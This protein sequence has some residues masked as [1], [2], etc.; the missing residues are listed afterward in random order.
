[1]IEISTVTN[2]FARAFILMTTL[3]ILSCLPAMAQE[4]EV[5]G[6][7]TEGAAA[8]LPGVSV[9]LKG[10]S[11]GTVTDIDGRYSLSVPANGVLVFSFVGFK[12][13]EI[14][15]SSRSSIDL[16]MELD[17]KALEEIVVVGYGEQ[18]RSDLTGAI[19]TVKSEDIKNLPVNSVADAI[20][21]RVAGVYVT[22]S[23]GE[24][25][26]QPN[27]TI[28][29]PGNLNGVAPLY[30]V[31]GMPFF[32]TGF[33][34]NIQD[35]E[36]IEVIK[37]ASAAAIY[38]TLGSGGVI[39]ITTKKGQ[40][41]RITT[42]A[43]VNYGV[44]RVFNLPELLGRDRYIQ[45]QIANGAPPDQFNG[46]FPD[47]DWFDEL[48]DA[49]IEQNYTAYLSGGGEKST[50]YAS[51]NYQSLEGVRID[52][53]VERYTLRL[54]SEHKVNKRLTVGQTLYGTYTMSNPTQLPNSGPLS[55]RTSPLVPVREPNGEWGRDTFSQRGNAVAE[56]FVNFQEDE[57]YILN[58]SAYVDWEIIDGLHFRTNGGINLENSNSYYFNY[59]FDFGRVERVQE[60]FGR[61]FA[62]RRQLLANYTLMYT[63]NFNDKHDVSAM[64]GYEA[65]KDKFSN[66]QGNAFFPQVPLAQNSD[67]SV[68]DTLNRP[69]F[70]G[71]D[72]YRILSQF[73]RINYSYQGKYLAQF[74]VR[75][76]GVA[77]VFGP[78]NKYGVFP[79]MSLGWKI[80]EEN[81]MA[82]VSQVSNLKLRF[83]LGSLGNFQGID[84]FLF[85]GDFSPGFAVDLGGGKQGSINL[86]NKLPNE[87]IQ[88]ETIRTLNIGVDAGFFENKLT[89]SVDWYDRTTQDMLYQVPL[90]AVAGL[91]EDVQFNIGE[92]KNTGL[93]FALE[94]RSSVGDVSYNI[95]ANGAFNRNELVS[96]SPDVI[97]QQIF[98]GST[99]EAYAFAQASR[100]A[101][102]EPLGQFW[103]FVTDGIYQQDDPDGPSLD[104][105]TPLAG[106]LVYRNI[107]DDDI[108]ND[109][110]K[111][112]IGNPW[113]D[114]NYGITMGAQ[115]K[116]FD[117]QLFFTGVQGVDILNTT[118]SFEHLFFN[119]YHSTEAIYRTSFFDGNG[120]TDLPRSTER[121]WSQISDFNVQDGSFLRLKNL[122]VGYN[123][124]QAWLDKIHASSLRIFFMTDNLF[125]ITSYDGIDPESALS[126]RVTATS[127]TGEVQSRGIDNSTFRYPNSR[128]FSVGVNVE[129]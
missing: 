122:Q 18:K 43:N 91:G 38:G 104:G 60:E 73:G 103:G 82:S 7:V 107:T 55:F 53:L 127:P 15:V 6:R 16:N 75:R 1:M 64:I 113:P 63:K 111:T 90:S 121:N 115:W 37:D 100:S 81:F 88:W 125:T 128:L 32:G 59:A 97:D 19:A 21:G 41:D 71:A 27:I 89:L 66:L 65:R 31:D 17:I 106:D 98:S 87:D 42:G 3:L 58:A 20:Q 29:G 46:T 85:I 114:F 77:T 23:S 123:L 84:N 76:D 30:V 68:T 80:S 126:G 10:T 5:S 112:F 12:T 61:E 24:P 50:F 94:Y 54:N 96:L 33:N 36:S 13:T 119:D 105:S 78:G 117:L 67:L 129:F 109:D 40:S 26:S 22:P 2:R 118:R 86:S 95:G 92:V 83:S 124:P 120:V 101:P 62:N 57:S 34:F 93:E 70:R 14:P 56:E 8:P 102:G 47:T 69:V 45:A 52:N 44:R 108:I 79:S 49:G 11:T 9:L 39:L 51:M 4:I 72:N 116:G 110:D 99:N 35:I 48:Y 28:R 74:N 25:G